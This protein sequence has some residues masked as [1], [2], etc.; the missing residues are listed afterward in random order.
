LND[1]VETVRR[2]HAAIN[3]LDF[4]AIAASF[5][6][7]AIYRSNGVGAV[8]GKTAILGAFRRYFA[9]YPDQVAHDDLIEL[10]SPRAVRSEWRLTATHA[11]TG[12]PLV[13]HGEETVYLNA[14]GL[15]ERVEVSDRP[16]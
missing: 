15:I 16:D 8:E 4:E 12:R 1:P 14:A 13:R 9:V 6:E 5:A 3:A 2:Y 7:D 10:M 11:R